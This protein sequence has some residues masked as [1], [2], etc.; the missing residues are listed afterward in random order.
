MIEHYDTA[1]LYKL[2]RFAVLVQC[3]EYGTDYI[4]LPCLYTSVETKT[5][6]I[7]VDLIFDAF[8]TCN[9][10]ERI[11]IMQTASL[12]FRLRECVLQNVTEEDNGIIGCRG[13]VI[14]VHDSIEC[15]AI[16]SRF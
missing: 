7:C 6:N 11:E 9:I 5:Y 3:S 2:F 8:A 4:E 13:V 10:L 1:R 15:I 12:L 14:H 16:A